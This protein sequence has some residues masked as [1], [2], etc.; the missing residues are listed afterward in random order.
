MNGSEA[1]DSQAQA[2]PGGSPA[3]AASPHV[4]PRRTLADRVARRHQG[5]IVANR[6][7]L[8]RLVAP[9]GLLVVLSLL[10]YP[11]LR[12]RLLMY[13]AR[14]GSR[15]EQVEAWH[16]LAGRDDP[17]ALEV[18]IEAL[19]GLR[20]NQSFYGLILQHLGPR[21]ERLP[22]ALAMLGDPVVERRRGAIYAVYAI[23][24]EPHVAQRDDIREA[25]Q[26]ALE[27]DADFRCRLYAIHALTDLAV[28]ASLPV[29]VA[30]SADE[31][32]RICR[33][34][35]GA[36]AALAKR[37]PGCADEVVARLLAI[38]D[39]EDAAVRVAGIEALGDLAHPAAHD[40]L[41][42]LFQEGDGLE[43]ATA[44]AALASYGIQQ[45][46]PLALRAARETDPVFRATAVAVLVLDPA[47]GAQRAVVALV[48]DEDL[49]V[50]RR[51]YEVLRRCVAP[52][53]V[54]LGL[55]ERLR[56]ARRQ[57]VIERCHSAIARLVGQEPEDLP[58]GQ[59]SQVAAKQATYW[60]VVVKA[61]WQ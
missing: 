38:L 5:D 28:E 1:A 48:L 40:R 35:P 41:L 30:A 58:A 54:A 39:S 16:E 49:D 27:S 2:A 25:M 3:G 45:V 12:F 33:L 46:R 61:R 36:L 20:N 21:P 26:R 31:D 47:L 19:G 57:P 9:L 56:E 32:G 14:H 17:R 44:L 51:A 52:K 55:V 43:A 11:G 8:L 6:R 22:V 13:Q 34:V 15:V 50:R 42:T 4:V 37:S 7:W 53:G 60:A 24:R 10:A 23:R 29:L 18:Y 59:P